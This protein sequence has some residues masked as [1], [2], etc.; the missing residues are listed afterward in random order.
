MTLQQLD[1]IY[2]DF[3]VPEQSLRSLA[4]GQEVGMTVDAIP[5][6]NF[7]GK[8]EAIDARVS[9]EYAQRHSSAPSSPIP[10]TSFCPACSPI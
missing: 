7:E 3:P 5:G 4:I 8:I 2:V 6:R 1:P 9:A 10:T